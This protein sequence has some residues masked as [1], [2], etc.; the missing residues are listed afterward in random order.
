LPNSHR[1]IEPELM[2]RLMAETH[3]NDIISSGLEVKGLEL[4]DKRSSVGSLS[5]NDEFSMEEC[6]NF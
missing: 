5:N 3:V 2:R 1:K 6:I 4:I